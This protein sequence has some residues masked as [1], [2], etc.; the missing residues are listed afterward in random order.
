MT[1]TLLGILPYSGIKFYTFQ[2]LKRLW[3]DAHA[4]EAARAGKPPLTLTLLAGG[5]AGLVAQTV[6]YPMDI[7][8]RRMQVEAL[9][10]GQAARHL[11]MAAHARA[12]VHEY[13]ARGLF[14]GLLI[15]YLKV[16]PSTAV[17]FTMY[18]LAKQALHLENHL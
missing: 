9:G 6:T 14:R 16:V 5:A 1:P 3:R 2:K 4:G 12:I 7:V 10:E 15:N 18:D 17:G 8:R 11:S 13:G